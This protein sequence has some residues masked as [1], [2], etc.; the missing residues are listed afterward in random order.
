[1]SRSRKEGILE[2]AVTV[3]GGLLGRGAWGVRAASEYDKGRGGCH[4][5]P[6]WET[7]WGGAVGWERALCVWV[8]CL[9]GLRA[10]AL[11]ESASPD[12]QF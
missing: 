9:G 11:G 7:C 4:C 3:G 1:M 12:C 8:W 6:G 2:A 10:L 5:A